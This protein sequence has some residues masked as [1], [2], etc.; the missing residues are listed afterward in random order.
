MALIWG[1]GD[2][3][4]LSIWMFFRDTEVCWL[5]RRRTNW[6]G[7]GRLLHDA[8]LALKTILFAG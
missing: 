4:A 6:P 3:M 5:L 7:G 1:Y 2:T 8:I